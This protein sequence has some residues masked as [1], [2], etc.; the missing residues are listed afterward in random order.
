MIPP[1]DFDPYELL[2][3]DASADAAT[4]DRAYKAR[5][6]FVH[7][8]IAGTAGLNETKRLNVAREW[9]LDPDLRAQLP[10]PSVPWWE[11]FAQA[12]PP[13][14]PSP[15][16]WSQDSAPP[17]PR[18]KPAWDYDPLDDDPL[19]FDFGAHT[20]ELRAFFD[21]I[22]SLSRDERERLNYSL[23]DEPP[24]LFDE[25]KDVV[26]ERL[27]ARSRALEDAI[28]RVWAER[29]DENAPLLF[30]R[31]RVYGNGAVVANA[32]A[33]WLLLADAIRQR[34]RDPATIDALASRCTW[35]WTA[36]VGR[37]RYGAFE[38]Q[39]LAF[40][41]DA[42]GLSVNAAERLARSWHR[43]FGTY[44]YGRPGEDW[45][46]GSLEHPKPLLVSARLAAVDASRIEPPEG[47]DYEQHNGYRCGLRLTAYVLALG[48]VDRPGRDYLGPW[49][50]ALD[51]NPSFRDRARWGMP[52]G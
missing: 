34:T 45:F 29:L 13:P 6:R 49:R 26:S 28:S 35:A 48:G 7:P 52:L 11:R 12:P 47:L 14:P 25:F 30:P 15:P 31:G 22:R 50:D 17:P 39:V 2:G 10:P 1:P 43:H 9:L 16:R 41:D 46:P 51:P 18:Q 40:L 33:Q 23:G 8:D 4:I 19:A 27:W 3:V 20:D 32:Y 24:L 44:L 38:R 36:S 42:E 21:S 37:D 5:I